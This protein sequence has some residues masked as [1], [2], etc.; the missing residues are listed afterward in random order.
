MKAKRLTARERAAKDLARCQRAYDRAE[1][2]LIRAALVG[3]VRPDPTMTDQDEAS[4]S[5]RIVDVAPEVRE[6]REHRNYVTWAERDL[7]RAWL[8][9]KG[10]ERGSF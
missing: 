8:G 5:G 1:R 6:L 7:A 9:K 4:S 10:R 3:C 2:R